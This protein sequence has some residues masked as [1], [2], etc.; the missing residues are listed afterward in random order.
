MHGVAACAAALGMLD[1]WMCLAL[2]WCV[3]AQA[4][5]FVTETNPKKLDAWQVLS[6]SACLRQHLQCLLGANV[7]LTVFGLF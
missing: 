7:K 5:M 2:P 4:C 1:W 6:C 3:I